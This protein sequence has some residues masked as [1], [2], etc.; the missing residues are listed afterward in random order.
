[1]YAPPATLSIPVTGNYFTVFT[2]NAGSLGLLKHPLP[3]NIATF[4]TRAFAILEDLRRSSPFTVE[5]FK[6][7]LDLFRTTRKVGEEVVA[8]LEKVK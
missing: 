6:S 1:M 8:A 7:L 3:R 2:S 4:Y 5:E